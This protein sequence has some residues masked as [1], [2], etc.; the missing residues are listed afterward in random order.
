MRLLLT[1][2]L[3]LGSAA[4]AEI[5]R[6]TAVDR[7]A[8]ALLQQD[9][10]AFNPHYKDQREPR[11]GRTYALAKRMFD[12][13]DKGGKTTCGHQIL[14]ELESLLISSADF[15]L[16][17][18]RLRDLE[19][20]IGHPSSDKVDQDGLWGACYQQWYLKYATY[21][22]LEAQAGDEPSPH[23]L[24]AFLA[25]V[26]TPEKLTAYLDAL[27]VSDVRYTGLDHEPEFNETVATLLQ[28]IVRRK[29][30]NYI[31]DPTLRDALLD[32]VLH[33]Y[34]NLE[35]GF[36]GERYRRE[37]REDF[38][39][40]LSVTFH[41]VSYLKGKVPEMPHVLDTTL[42]I[43]DFNYPAG[44]L[45]KGE[46]WN[47]NNMDVVALFHLGWAQASVSQQKAMATE[48]DRM[49]TWCLHDS[50]QPD[51]SFKVNIADGSLEDAE[52]YG[53]SFLVRI[54]FFDPAQRFWTDRDFQ[55]APDVR[56]RILGFVRAHQG[57]GPTGD[58]YR[59]TLEA[60]GVH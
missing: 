12:E 37:G 8:F 29:P 52:Y 43:K 5:P 14:F 38:P 34:R 60:L 47:H 26:S 32:R 42:A 54:G 30:E 21:D 18:A 10:V 35:T 13:E 28:M 51:G 24:P 40:D 59:S 17:D 53:T 16:I 48:I 50:L 23:P 25:R 3:I 56:K 2:V 44:W 15:K 36:W 31:V 57:S 58:N 46:F 45:W 55:E 1:V 20:S 33:R 7:D 11:V 22:H 27:S 49:L 41:V 39:D 4:S 6:Q 19:T 9:F